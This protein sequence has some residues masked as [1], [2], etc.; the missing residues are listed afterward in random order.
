MPELDVEN[1]N[2]PPFYFI[3]TLLHFLKCFIQRLPSDKNESEIS[4]MKVKDRFLEKKSMKS[5]TYPFLMFTLQ[6]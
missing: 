2:N 5:L 3:I 6:E 4:S 1:P